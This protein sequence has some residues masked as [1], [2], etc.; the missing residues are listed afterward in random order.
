MIGHLKT[1]DLGPIG[2]RPN[3]T[4]PATKRLALIEL[5]EL[6]K[7]IVK[8]LIEP[9]VGDNLFKN[10]CYFLLNA[11]EHVPRKRLHVLFRIRRI[12]QVWGSL[13][14]LYQAGRPGLT[15]RGFLVSGKIGIGEGHFILP[16]QELF[17]VPF[18]TDSA[19]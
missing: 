7:G 1:S 11:L 10:S 6:N 14:I 4:P 5:V 17:P 2:L 3:K 16:V 15:S 13:H 8:I 9:S 19:D 18:W 12:E